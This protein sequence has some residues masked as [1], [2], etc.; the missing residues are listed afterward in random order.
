MRTILAVIVLT[1]VAFASDA[2][3]DPQKK[4][5][6]AEKLKAPPVPMLIPSCQFGAIKQD[7]RKFTIEGS[8]SWAATGEISKDG[9]TASVTWFRLPEG[10]LAAAVYAIEASGEMRGSWQRKRSTKTAN[11]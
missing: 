8:E 2:K 4:T 6:Q 7:G 5:P 11:W 9:K 1:F 10:R 3:P